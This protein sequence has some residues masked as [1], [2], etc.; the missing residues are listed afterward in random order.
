MPTQHPDF[1]TPFLLPATNGLVLRSSASGYR[2]G[3]GVYAHHRTR[4]KP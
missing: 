1:G 2:E 4:V 3:N